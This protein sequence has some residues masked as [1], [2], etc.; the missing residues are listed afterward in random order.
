MLHTSFELKLDRYTVEDSLDNA[1]R[2]RRWALSAV[3]LVEVKI[4]LLPKAC[5]VQR[6]GL[7]PDAHFRS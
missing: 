3:G 2:G 6:S 5:V 4:R 1:S 7:G